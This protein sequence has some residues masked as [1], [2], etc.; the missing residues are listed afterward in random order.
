MNRQFKGINALV[1]VCLVLLVATWCGLTQAQV[2]DK[3][4]YQGYLT[5]NVGA[6]ITGSRSMI[7]TLY[8]AGG[9]VKYAETQTV[10]VA[11]GVFNVAIG[12]VTAMNLPFDIPYF[13]GVKVGAD[14][15][16]TP[17]QAVLSSPY[18]QRADTAN[19]LA[20]TATVGGSQIT[21]S[22]NVATLPAV[23]LSG[24][25]GTAQI[26][27]N[28][29]TQAKLSPVVGGTS[30]KVLG[31]DGTNLVWQAPAG[32]GTVTGVSASAPLASS[33]GIAP[34]ISLTG[35]VPVANGGTGQATLATNG[36]LIGQGTG[37]VSATVGAVGQVLTGAVGAPAWSGSP[38]LS[39]NLTLVTPSTATT[40]NIQKGANRFIH[41]FGSLNT[42][43]GENAGN[44]TLTGSFNSA[45][46]A[47]ALQANTTG[48]NNTA[49]G[50]AALQ[51]NTS[52]DGNTATGH[53]A[54]Q[55]NSNGVNNAAYGDAALANETT[56][57]NNTAIGNAALQNITTGIS[58]IGIGFGAGFSLKADSSQN[59]DIGNAGF[60]GDSD[61]IRIGT[62]GVQFLAYIQGIYN[63]PA[64][65]NGAAVFVEPDGRLGTNPSSRR[66]K[67]DIADMNA[68]SNA[69][70][71]LRPV[72]FH[73]KS[74][75]NPAGP[76]L[77][78]GL[79]AEEV[80]E[81][82]PGLVAHSADGQVQGV[83]YQFLAPML[84]NEYQNQQRTIDAQAWAIRS[85]TMRIAELERDRQVQ[86]A[87]IEALETRDSELALLRQQAAQLALLQRQV[88]QL[89]ADRAQ[90]AAK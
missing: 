8:D 16:M 13:L 79:V 80:A 49:I 54:L 44:F 48:S 77:Q 31:T 32:G 72:T 36:V 53:L 55:K 73:Y 26:A 19:L 10:N 83:M 51:L 11:S 88:A 30:G 61:T 50:Y 5:D 67:D 24:A 47:S 40:G 21:G 71:Q 27:N 66:Y 6:P 15:E 17:R 20:A 56:G 45:S 3:L 7:F 46:G 33:G 84:L 35:S 9:A 90:L 37:A 1:H 60:V 65:V 68:A 23:Q 69:L 87:R 38:V 29:V 41:N 89:A 86:L 63:A 4:N 58:N 70:M 74:D 76:T 75:H 82:Y 81:V 78:Y 18:A 12:S 34:N 25:I 85:Q 28:A 42:F 22:I 57:G 62:V 39:G 52:G 64:L 14:P 43:I 2:P 59:I